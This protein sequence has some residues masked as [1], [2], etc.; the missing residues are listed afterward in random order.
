MKRQIGIIIGSL[1]PD[2]FNRK[3]ALHVKNILDEK[4]DT[5]IIAIDK[6][7]LY[8]EEYDSNET[9]E[10]KEYRAS[11]DECDGFIFFT[12]EYNRSI[13]GVLKNAIDV[14]SRPYGQSKWDSKPSAIFSASPGAIGG[15]GATAHLR[16]VLSFLNV[17]LMNQPEVYLSNIA[18]AIQED[19]TINERT[20]TFLKEAVEAYTIHLEK[21]LS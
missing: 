18:E 10:Y 20:S 6:L 16:L 21:H 14:G 3:V 8:S 5:S 1:R 17:P 13:P 19:G 11:L 4:Y 9:P 12:P 7:Q 2:S 15:F